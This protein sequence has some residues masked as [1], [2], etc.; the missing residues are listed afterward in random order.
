[1]ACI[2]SEVI[3]KFV[4]GKVGEVMNIYE[5]DMSFSR[6]KDRYLVFFPKHFLMYKVRSVDLEFI[7]NRLPE[8]YKND[9]ELLNCRPCLE[10][11]DVDGS[12][13][14]MSVENVPRRKDCYLCKYRNL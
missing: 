12:M 7:W 9:I 1:M 13:W 4:V 14:N 2:L 3:I 8:Y 5:R 11:Y 6:I 10:H